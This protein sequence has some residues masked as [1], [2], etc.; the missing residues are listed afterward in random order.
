MNL[1]HDKMQNY[2]Q[3][4]DTQQ[5]SNKYKE[6]NNKEHNIFSGHL[7]STSSVLLSDRAC[8]RNF[9]NQR[10]LDLVR[11]SRNTWVLNPFP[12]KGFPIDE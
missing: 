5:E 10:T 8:D 9:N 4:R 12:S 1:R 3:N 11:L 7:S 2:R 6:T